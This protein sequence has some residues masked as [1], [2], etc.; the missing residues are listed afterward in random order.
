VSLTNE[1]GNVNLCQSCHVNHPGKFGFPWSDGDQAVPGESGTSHRW[2]ALATNRG[3]TP[4]IGTAMADYARLADGKLQCSTCHDQHQADALL[5][6]PADPARLG[7]QHTSFPVDVAQPPTTGG[8]GR[9]LTLA[10]PV[11]AA[12][13]AK[14]YLVEIVAGGTAATATF[15]L[16][17][18]GGKSWF[19][20]AAPTDYTW[21]AF[22]SNACRAGPSVPLNDGANVT[23]AFGGAPGTFVAGDRWSFYVA[24]PYL[25]VSNKDGEMCTTCHKDRHMFWQDVEG[26]VANG[27]AGGRLTTVSLGTTVFHHPVGQKLNDDGR[28]NGIPAILEPDGTTQVAG[29][30]NATN[31][32][33]V[34]TDGVVTCLTCHRPHNTDS[35]S[36]SVDPR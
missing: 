24:Y 16:S 22:A 12:A 32:L 27:I 26:G 25:R 17:N 20:C 35:N 1:V 4:P 10:G 29:D 31:D 9:T 19:G 34:G 23:V 13:T 2:D 5:G 3:A 11:G 6:S 36:L 15:R 30:G 7:T 21:V 18:D 33:Q 28:T 14:A 8:T